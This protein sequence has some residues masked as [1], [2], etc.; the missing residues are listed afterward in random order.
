MSIKTAGAF[1]GSLGWER[2]RPSGNSLLVVKGGARCCHSDL[3][4]ACE[5]PALFTLSTL[6][7]TPRPSAVCAQHRQWW[8]ILRDGAVMCQFHP[9]AAPHV[10][11]TCG[12]MAPAFLA[13]F[14]DVAPAEVLVSK[15]DPLRYAGAPFD[16]DAGE[17]PK[18]WYRRMA[19]RPAS[20]DL[21]FFCARCMDERSGL[22]LLDL[23]RLTGSEY[24]YAATAMLAKQNSY[25]DALLAVDASNRI[26]VRNTEAFDV[27]Q[28]LARN[29][30]VAAHLPTARQYFAAA[31]SYLASLVERK[32][33]DDATGAP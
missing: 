21:A 24:L 28:A 23:S 14:S 19:Q 1:V 22:F 11:A 25:L 20:P 30:N 16:W 2:L 3:N 5:N 13:R 15:G 4:G 10:C 31:I 17:G 12:H 7:V 26:C 32:V 9:L 6:Y 18:F 8:D 33:V 29:P 27:F